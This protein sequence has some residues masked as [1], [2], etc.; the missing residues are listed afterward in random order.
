MQGTEYRQKGAGVK[1][2][3]KDSAIEQLAYL[4]AASDSLRDG[5]AI[6]YPDG[7]LI[8]INPIGLALMGARSIEDVAALPRFGF[9][10]A[11]LREELNERF[12]A[13]LRGDPDASKPVRLVYTALDGTEHIVESC[14]TRLDHPDGRGHAVLHVSREIDQG[15][16]LLY[17]GDAGGS[18]LHAILATVPDAM[19]VI[20]E[21][22]RI[23]SFSAAAEKLF[24]YEEAQ[25]RGRNVNMLMPSPYR[26]AHDGYIH[27][28]LTTGEKRIIGI[29][30]E[31]LGLKRDGSV[32]PI[33]L[34][35]GEAR[36]GEHRVFTGFIRDLTERM[37]AESELHKVQAD[38]AHASRLSAV[39]TL[40]SSLAHELSQPLTSITNYASA[41]R[42]MVDDQAFATRDIVREALDNAAKEAVRA[43]QIVRRIR[44]FVSRGEIRL[45]SLPL[46][47]LIA[48]ATSL[49]LVGAKEKGVQW[50]ID[51]DPEAGNVFA[52]LIQIQ[53]VLFN[54]MRNAIEAMENSPDKHLTIHARLRGES[55]VVISV[56]DT[57]PGIAPEVRQ[58]LFQ[59]FSTTKSHGMGLGLSICRTIIE[60]HGGQLW[61]EEG[62]NCGI[63]MKFTLIRASREIDD[64][65]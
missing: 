5:I 15:E 13:T 24:G 61:M 58:T 49:G 18:L 60:A 21:T 62:Y 36:F 32:F 57:G 45:Q 14:M 35:V 25:V 7:R 46:G 30:R 23:T 44:D 64:A 34:A 10:H 53:Q 3:A 56:C 27:R 55:Q 20:D 63:I 9:A 31:V 39:G 1:S 33:E 16:D 6:Y 22:G 4:K 8:S 54:L 2:Q 41:A 40:A 19:I 42:D 26:E 11:E 37:R 43:G 59:P 17:S 28:H 48:D 51:I 38:L 29:G 47:R 52:D 50:W 65:G 12:A